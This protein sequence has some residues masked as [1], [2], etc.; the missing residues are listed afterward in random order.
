MASRG[1]DQ[2]GPES[3]E[4]SGIGYR[5]R[6][7]WVSLLAVALVDTL[8]F[9][10]VVYAWALGEPI[11]ADGLIGLLVLITLLL[12]AIALMFTWAT[13][14]A[15]E[16]MDERDQAI[17]SSSA[18]LGYLVLVGAVV[19][20]LALHLLNVN[21]APGPLFGLALFDLP[22]IEVHLLLAG[23]VTSELVR[24]GAALLQ[25]HQGW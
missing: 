13:R 3:A 1:L 10:F 22:L 16:P 11:S 25:Y 4:G 23:L 8:Y 5:E 15:K 19:V 14:A 18:R 12:L 17:A 9:A 24:Y 20:G 2:P 6:S 21:Q 7:L